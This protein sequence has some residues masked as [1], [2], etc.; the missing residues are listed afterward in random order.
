MD[1]AKLPIWLLASSLAVFAAGFL[2]S[3]FYLKETRY[4]MEMR[5]GPP[6]QSRS[7]ALEYRTCDSREPGKTN[8]CEAECSTGSSV[9]GGGCSVEGSDTSYAQVFASRPIGENRWYCQTAMDPQEKKE[10]IAT[11]YAICLKTE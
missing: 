5:F 8:G 6:D 4:F 10:V 1:L 2:L 3:L 7:I 11:A 9:V